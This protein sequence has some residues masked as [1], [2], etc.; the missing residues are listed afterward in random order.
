LTQKLP[1]VKTRRKTRKKTRDR[2]KKIPDSQIL[3]LSQM[4]RKGK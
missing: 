4:K 2:V 3:K 1:E